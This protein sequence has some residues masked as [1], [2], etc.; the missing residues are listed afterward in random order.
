MPDLALASAVAPS[1]PRPVPP[2][3][4][5]LG[6]PGEGS[7]AG[8]EGEPGEVDPLADESHPDAARAERE[9]REITETIEEH[10][11]ALVRAALASG[12]E[13]LE[14]IVELRRAAR[15]LE[16]RYRHGRDQRSH[17]A[18]RRPDLEEPAIRRPRFKVAR[19]I[20]EG[21]AD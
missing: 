5:A 17:H 20:V 3:P 2:A 15:A 8:E 4:V 12:R 21:G 14:L 10:A 19:G 18:D 11:A 6:E 7:L 13:P 9:A 1:A 16:V